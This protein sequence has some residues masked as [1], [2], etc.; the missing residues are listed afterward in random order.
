MPDRD[1]EEHVAIFCSTCG[2]TLGADEKAIARRES[3]WRGV[4]LQLSEKYFVAAV[5]TVVNFVSALVT[6]ILTGN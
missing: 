4:R 5:V 2:R 1:L 6:I 3:D